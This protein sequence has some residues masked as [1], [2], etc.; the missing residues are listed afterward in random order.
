VLGG[1]AGE[2][3][4]LGGRLGRLIDNMM[5]VIAVNRNLQLFVNLY[6]YLNPILPVL[7]VAPFFLSGDVHDFGQVTQSANAF[8][9]VLGAFSVLVN[10]FGQITT[11]A[12]VTNRLAGLEEALE[13]PGSRS[14]V[15]VELRPGG[16]ALRDVTVMARENGAVLVKELSVEVPAGGSLLVTGPQGSGKTALFRAVAGLGCRG[17]GHVRRPPDTVFLPQRPYTPSG[18]LRYLLTYTDGDRAVKDEELLEALRAV[19]FAPLVHGS[20]SLDDDRAWGEVLSVGEQQQVAFARLLLRRPSF[21]FL[22]DAL[23]ALDE[24]DV[25]KLYALLPDLGIGYVTF[26]EH[27]LSAVHHDQVVELTGEGHWRL[28]AAAAAGVR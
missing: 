8:P 20:V 5:H 16:V 12:A 17:T 22:D 26:S 21:V 18:T 11:L 15:S 7:I 25:R 1:E 2:R 24:P 13:S 4:R 6:G 28:R 9:F 19:D 3:R 10:Q 23:S 14:C 27:A